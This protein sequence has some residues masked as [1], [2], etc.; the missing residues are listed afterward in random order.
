MSLKRFLIFAG[1][2]YYPSR[3]MGDFL[4]DVD[5]EVEVEA[6]FLVWQ[7]AAD[8][9]RTFADY[10]YVWDTYTREEYKSNA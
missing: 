2:N 10:M 3:G 8:K 7:A 9:E 4:L 1:D 6:F 5:S